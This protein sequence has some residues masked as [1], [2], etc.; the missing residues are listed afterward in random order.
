M[1]MVT[2]AGNH[3]KRLY[4]VHFIWGSWASESW[5]SVS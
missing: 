4:V 1:K 3:R 2:L 5:K